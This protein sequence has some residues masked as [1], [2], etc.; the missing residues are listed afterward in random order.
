MRN[1]TGQRAD[2]LHFLGM[3]YL[4]FQTLAFFFFI[5]DAFKD[6]AVAL[7]GFFQCFFGLFALGNIFDDTKPVLQFATVV[8]DCSFP[9]DRPQITAIFFQIPVF[10]FVGI[11][12]AVACF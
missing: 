6:I 10:G 7:L 12:C 11:D 1:S 2:G 3:L 8:S 9:Y 4:R 5:L